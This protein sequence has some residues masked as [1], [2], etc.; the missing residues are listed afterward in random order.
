MIKVQFTLCA[1]VFVPIVTNHVNEL[2]CVI[3]LQFDGR[4][5]ICSAHFEPYCFYNKHNTSAF[6]Y[7]K[8][9]RLLCPTAVPSI[10]PASDQR[11]LVHDCTENDVEPDDSDIKFEPVTDVPR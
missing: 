1:Y 2:S 3:G 9:K 10:F 8:Q 5:L 7:N 11:Q 6:L 4:K